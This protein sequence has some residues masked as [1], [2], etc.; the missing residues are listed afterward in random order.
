LHALASIK[1]MIDRYLPFEYQPIYDKLY[2][3]KSDIG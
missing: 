2:N 1:L 3:D